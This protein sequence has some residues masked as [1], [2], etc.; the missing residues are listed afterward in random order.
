MRYFSKCNDSQTIPQVSKKF[1]KRNAW[2][3]VSSSLFSLVSFYSTTKDFSTLSQTMIIHTNI[4]ETKRRT[5]FLFLRFFFFCIASTLRSSFE[6]ILLG[7]SFFLPSFCWRNNNKHLT[8][9]ILPSLLTILLIE[10]HNVAP[11]KQIMNGG[12]CSFY[13]QRIPL[14]NFLCLISQHIW[15]NTEQRRQDVI[16]CKKQHDI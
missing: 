16:D 13:D 10:L 6:V 1:R 3:P 14:N 4:F 11:W 8:Q 7:A 9:R 12:I 2:Y 5:F 15:E